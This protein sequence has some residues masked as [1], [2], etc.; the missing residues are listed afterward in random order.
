MSRLDNLPEDIQG[1]I[2]YHM[3]CDNYFFVVQDRIISEIS[4]LTIYDVAYLNIIN[5]ANKTILKEMC[6]SVKIKPD[7]VE[8]F[9]RVNLMEK[10][11][12][13]KFELFD[14]VRDY[15][16]RSGK[17]DRKCKKIKM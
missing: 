4:E 8:Y 5:K 16:I 9:S 3:L 15:W 14:K 10:R 17:G 11:L 12:N 2:K 1:L 7:K 13:R 6:K